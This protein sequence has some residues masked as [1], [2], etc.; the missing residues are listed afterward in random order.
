M[1]APLFQLTF[2]VLWHNIFGEVICRGGTAD[3]G[4]RAVSRCVAKAGT[5]TALNVM[6]LK[7]CSAHIFL[8]FL[9]DT[10]F[11]V[12]YIRQMSKPYVNKAPAH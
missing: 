6:Q 1:S 12:L 7:L 8:L 3:W 9:A 5:S 10:I 4:C 2:F 11:R